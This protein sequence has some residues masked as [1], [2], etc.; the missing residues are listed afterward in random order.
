VS[1]DPD[2]N[3][4]FQE[5]L[6]HIVRQDPDV[7]VIGMG[8]DPSL[9]LAATAE[10]YALGLSEVTLAELEIKLEDFMKRLCP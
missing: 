10:A 5:T 6:R 1:I 2:I 8:C 3:L 7:V 4:T 9:L